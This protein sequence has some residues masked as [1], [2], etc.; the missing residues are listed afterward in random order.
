MYTICQ[1]KWYCTVDMVSKLRSTGYIQPTGSIHQ[2]QGNHPAAATI[3]SAGNLQPNLAGA[4]CK[5]VS[6]LMSCALIPG[7]TLKIPAAPV[8]SLQSH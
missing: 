3:Q 5:R 4:R 7:A 1:P 8:K 6:L 2:A